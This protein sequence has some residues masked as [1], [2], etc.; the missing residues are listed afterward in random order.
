MLFRSV[1]AGRSVPVMSTYV[2]FDYFSGNLHTAAAAAT[3]LLLMIV[4]FVVAYFWLIERR[5]EAV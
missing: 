1:L 5:R 3:V 2:Y 4:I